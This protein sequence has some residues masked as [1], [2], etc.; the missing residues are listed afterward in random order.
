MAGRPITVL[1]SPVN[2]STFF[3]QGTLNRKGLEP[4]RS[5]ERFYLMPSDAGVVEGD[6]IQ[7]G[8]DFFLVM[9][10]SKEGEFG[11]TWAF[12][13]TLYKTNSLVSV[14]T[15]NEST[16]VF[17]PIKTGVNC[18]ITRAHAFRGAEDDMAV[19]LSS[20]RGRGSLWTVYARVSEGINKD[21]ILVDQA[22]R[23]WRVSADSDPSVVSGVL[24]ADVM[25]G[26][27]F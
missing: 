3:W 13:G 1:R 12:Q 2:L 23:E 17:D 16:Q 11:E 10:L 18:L 21:S 8:T 20:A 26:K 5:Y 14:N 22:G 25:L 24:V 9:S 27:G 4:T 6:L 7:D 15:Y 19:A